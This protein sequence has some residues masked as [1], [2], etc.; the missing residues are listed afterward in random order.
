MELLTT[1]T[2]KSVSLRLRKIQEAGMQSVSWTSYCYPPQQSPCGWPS[3]NWQAAAG[4]CCPRPVS[5]TSRWMS[6]TETIQLSPK[7]KVWVEWTV[8][9][10]L[11]RL[12]SFEASSSLPPLW[13]SALMIDWLTVSCWWWLLLWIKFS[14][15]SIYSDTLPLCLIVECWAWRFTGSWLN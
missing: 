4:V 9:N 13:L 2:S 15:T 7:V 11:V 10:Q 1:V 14:R 12:F 6:L 5:W 8:K 3:I